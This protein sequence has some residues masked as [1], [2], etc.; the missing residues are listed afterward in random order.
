MWGV[1]G[2]HLEPALL[3]GTPP[4]SAHE[5]NMGGREGEGG[6]ERRGK[7]TAEP[8]PLSH[9]PGSLG[10]PP[11]HPLGFPVQSRTLESVVLWFRGSSLS[12]W[13]EP[14]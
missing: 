2:G 10:T 8:P 11:A 1:Y 7:E 9:E 3:P 4:L 12:L 13:R 6:R 14:L 5:S